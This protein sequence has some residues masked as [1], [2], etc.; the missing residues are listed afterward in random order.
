M[1]QYQSPLDWLKNQH[2]PMCQLL[3]AWSAITSGTNHLAGLAEQLTVL[4]AAFAELEGK[5]DIINLPPYQQLQTNGQLTEQTV[6][7]AL[8][9]SK[10]PDAPLQILLCGHMDT[11]YG[12]DHPFQETREVDGNTL[13]GPGVADM[14]GGIIVMLYALLA[15]ERSSFAE[16]IGWQV[17]LT[18]DEEI[19]SLSSAPL[20]AEL[21]QKNHLGLIYEPAMTPEGHL[22]GARK[23]S[24]KFSIIAHGQAAHAGRAFADGRNAISAMARIIADIEQLNN[25]EHGLTINVGRISGGSAVNIVPDLCICHLDVRYQQAEDSKQIEQN[26]QAIVNKHN[27]QEGYHIK[28]HGQITRPAKALE[29]KTLALFELV[30]QAGNELGLDIDWLPSGGC[31][32]GN[33]LA[34]C[35]LPVVDSLGVRGGR[36]HSE[37]EFVLLNSLVERAQ[38]SSLLLMKLAAGEYRL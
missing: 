14:K 16:Q 7:Q 9:V 25:N 3:L 29:G 28:L 32:D 23:G 33:N 22:A 26:L 2:S 15:L 8:C 34:A 38:L 6:G 13:N 35:G 10:R 36:I 12:E 17:L 31:C 1:D 37:Q 24:G 21:A 4:Q 5:Q 18:P 19:G 20:L 27:Q 30:K 11:V